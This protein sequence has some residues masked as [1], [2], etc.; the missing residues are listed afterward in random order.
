L[1][2]AIHPVFPAVVAVFV[3]NPQG[4]RAQDHHYSNCNLSM[5]SQ[6]VLGNPM[7]SSFG[8]RYRGHSSLACSTNYHK[9]STKTMQGYSQ[10]HT[11]LGR[12]S[13]QGI[14]YN[15]CHCLN[16][17]ALENY[18]TRTHSDYALHVE[19]VGSF[20]QRIIPFCSFGIS[21]VASPVHRWSWQVDFRPQ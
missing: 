12:G 4:T 13:L 21:L 14:L 17:A 2:V 3:A 6:L 16:N 10:D 20:D 5:K 19:Q 7:N 15:I 9:Q 18:S 11:C 8:S 1:V